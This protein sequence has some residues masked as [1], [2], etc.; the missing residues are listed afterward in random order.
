[1]DI[2][3]TNGTIVQVEPQS[4]CMAFPF[5]QKDFRQ[6]SIQNMRK[7]ALGVKAPPGWLH[8]DGPKVLNSPN[9]YQHD[10]FCIERL[11][12]PRWDFISRH[13]PFFECW[14][15]NA[16]QLSSPMTNIR[17]E[18]SPLASKTGSSRPPISSRR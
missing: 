13:V 1:L 3:R 8:I 14:H 9:R 10:L 2:R 4:K 17:N 7:N 15:S 11:A 12:R 16:N 5:L 18:P 6:Q